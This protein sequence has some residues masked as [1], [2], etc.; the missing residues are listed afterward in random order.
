MALAIT[1]NEPEHRYE[2]DVDGELAG[3]AVFRMRGDRIV[4]THTEVDDRFEGQGIGSAL[5]RGVLDAARGDGLGVLPYCPF[6]AGYIR[7]H[8][9]DYVDLVPTDQR[10]KFDL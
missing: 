7:G 3:F 5:A 10:A 9:D 4:F 8:P 2:A 1:L 6:I